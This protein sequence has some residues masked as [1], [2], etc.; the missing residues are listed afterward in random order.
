MG[1]P[2]PHRCQIP[3]LPRGLPE[4]IPLGS[5]KQVLSALGRF[6][7][8]ALLVRGGSEKRKPLQRPQGDG[9]VSWGKVVDRQGYLLKI[10]GLLAS[11]VIPDE[12]ASKQSPA[13]RAAGLFIGSPPRTCSGGAQ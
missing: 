12:V 3:F 7:K 10:G 13:L 11:L 8:W 1:M 9:G 6:Q 5:Q 2:H 4:S